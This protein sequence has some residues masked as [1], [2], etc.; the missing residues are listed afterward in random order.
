M[1]SDQFGLP[2]RNSMAKEKKLILQK[3]II[4][5]V[6]L[7]A[8]IGC[9][10]NESSRS[11][12]VSTN[13]RSF[14][15]ALKTPRQIKS[16]ATDEESIPAEISAL[17]ELKLLHLGSRSWVAKEPH[18]LS[19]LPPE[20]GSL[21]NLE[22][23]NLYHMS[24]LKTLP[25]EIEQLK[26]LKILKIKGVWHRGR[27]EDEQIGIT[28][29]Y[30]FERRGAALYPL[31]LS[32]LPDEIG[33]LSN[34][35]DLILYN[36]EVKILPESIGQLKKLKFFFCAHGDLRH[37]PPGIGGCE[38]LEF[39]NM[40]DN[41]RLGNFPP[42][43]G[44][45]SNLRAIWS[46][47]NVSRTAIPKEI[48]KLK[49]L[50][51]LEL[52]GSGLRIVPKELGDCEGL[53]SLNLRNGKFTQLPAELGNLQRLA[54]LELRGTSLT[55]IPPEWGNMHQLTV[56]GLQNTALTELP[57]ELGQL[58]NLRFLD[59]RGTKIL[60]LPDSFKNL[61]KLHFIAADEELAHSIQASLPHVHVSKTAPEQYLYRIPLLLV[62]NIVERAV[63]TGRSRTSPNGRP[64]T[65]NWKQRG[66]RSVTIPSPGRLAEL[67]LDGNDLEEI[68]P[69]IFKSKKLIKIGLAYNKLRALPLELGKLQLLSEIDIS[70]NAIPH[71]DVRAFSKEYPSIRI[72]LNTPP[73]VENRQDDFSLSCYR[74]MDIR[75]SQPKT[76][77]KINLDYNECLMFPEF[78]SELQNLEIL[79]L[80]A[81]SITVLP[82]ALAN[83]SQLKEL[84]MGCNLLADISPNIAQLQNLETLDLSVNLLADLPQEMSALK[85]LK[86]LNLSGNELT[87][88]P[89]VLFQ[90]PSLE[91]LDLRGN[92]IPEDEIERLRREQPTLIVQ[93]SQTSKGIE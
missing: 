47:L 81:N 61:E 7:V 4:C 30:H 26:K 11:Q 76:I 38:S 44:N 32:S 25:P 21:K 89:E 29:G 10:G 46:N 48:G 50:A 60:Q 78:L 40:P 67:Y 93:T 49:K 13:A 41:P 1:K 71:D 87:H 72:V 28:P 58:H 86:T 63:E 74:G 57:E 20:I 24:S 51:F 77:R 15:E 66:L 68:P 39:L 35:E 69:F 85:Q 5:V 3:I 88:L 23:L 9:V 34:L 73:L 75:F 31:G 14:K 80:N 12:T 36:T 65:L 8:F 52:F 64:F 22:Q 92:V 82:E 70:G 84:H 42:E 91:K 55:S 18:P 54:Y 6:L 62:R 43:I 79:R 59:L 53:R 56:L 16:L 17:T 2:K 83:V 33:G 45:C 19:I 37:I 27:T 90:L